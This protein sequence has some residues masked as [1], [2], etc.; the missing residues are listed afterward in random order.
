MKWSDGITDLMDMSLSKLWEMVMDRE[1]WC[2]AVHGVTMSQTWLSNWTELKWN[3]FGISEL[4]L[5]FIYSLIHP[6]F[7]LSSKLFINTTHLP[8]THQS[9]HLPSSSPTPPPSFFYHLYHCC[10]CLVAK[11]CPALLRTRLLCPLDFLG[12]NIGVGC[13]FLPQEIFPIQESNLHLLRLLH[14]QADSLAP[15]G[16]PKVVQYKTRNPH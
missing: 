5:L 9:S 12:K 7:P 10:S 14:W 2:G 11:L 4:S 13:H 1:T 8:S 3:S 6:S 16:K 15:P